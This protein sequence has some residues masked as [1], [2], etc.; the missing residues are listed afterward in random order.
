MMP[1][2]PDNEIRLVSLLRQ[3]DP[4]AMRQLYTTHIRYLTAVCARYVVNSEDVKDVLQESF[5]KIMSGI[6]SFSYRGKG[7]LRG[8][9]TKVTVNE[10]LKHLQRDNRIAFVGIS[11]PDHDQA[12]TEPDVDSIPSADLFRMIRELPDGYR[13][14]FNLY[15]IE[16]KS[17]REIAAL[18]NIKES[19][20]ASQLHRAKALLASKIRQYH[21]PL[22]TNI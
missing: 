7:S 5:L 6:A 10:A 15:V 4:D 3:G 20:S 21:N 8:W 19:T 2:E 9:L 18:L 11:V 22:S 13:T 1:D 16:N 14:I 17:H 12:D